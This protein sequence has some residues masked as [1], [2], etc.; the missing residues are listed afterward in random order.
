MPAHETIRHILHPRVAPPRRATIHEPLRAPRP[1]N[2]R[3]DAPHIRPGRGD[4]HGR[5]PDLAHRRR[6]H[7]RLHQ[8]HRDVVLR[9]LRPERRAPLLQE[10]LAAR[11]RGQQRGRDEPA[12]GSHGQDQPALA[13]HHARGDESCDAERGHAVHHDDLVHLGLGGLGEGYRDAVGDAD[14]VDQDGDIQSRDL[15]LQGGVIVVVVAGEVNGH[16]AG[17]RVEFLL[18]LLGDGVEFAGR[19]R[20]QEGA[21]PGFGERE[22][23]FLAQ[24][25]RGTGDDGPGLG[26]GAKGAELCVAEKR[27]RS[28]TRYGLCRGRRMDPFADEGHLTGLP[29]STNIDSRKRM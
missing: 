4:E 13:V 19:A 12:K 1:P 15:I 20:D 25:V 2:T 24:P 7:V 22:R 5:H 10:G 3:Q 26:G 9:Q 8:P 29:G 17:G 28:I 23:V 27:V 6:D 16:G 21:V 18:D 11:I 14:I